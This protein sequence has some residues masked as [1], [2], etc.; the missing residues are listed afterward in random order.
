MVS[1]VLHFPI[2]N[3]RSM[4]RASS[5]QNSH[6]PLCVGFIADSVVRMLGL[7]QHS[8]VRAG[9]LQTSQAKTIEIDTRC[10]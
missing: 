1:L 7:P 3:E 4:C 6:F 10:S 5:Y 8:H 9:P 2:T